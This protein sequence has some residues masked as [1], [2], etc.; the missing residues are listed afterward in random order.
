MATRSLHSR[1]FGLPALV[2]V[3]ALGLSVPA[4]G[5]S[6]DDSASASPE[7][8]SAPGAAQ[9][10]YVRLFDGDDFDENDDNLR[11]AGPAEYESLK[12][13]PDADGKNWNDEADSFEYGAG[14]IV[15][16]YVGEDFEGEIGTYDD[17]DGGRVN[18]KTHAEYEEPS[19]MK[20]D[21][22]E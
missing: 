14:T 7:P 6:S 20:I 10:C 18:D 9:G 2:L 12:N 1:L 3:C 22:R 8:P 13:L 17:A 4:C 11:V 21:C 16:L 5:G 19:S 15:T